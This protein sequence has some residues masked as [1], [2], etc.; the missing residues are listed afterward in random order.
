MAYNRLQLKLIKAQMASMQSSATQTNRYEIVIP[1]HIPRWV[2]PVARIAL[3]LTDVTFSA[4]CYLTAFAIRHYDSSIGLTELFFVREQNGDP[5]LGTLFAPY[6][7]LLPF[8]LIIR[9]LPTLY[10]DLYSLRGEFSY[11]DDAI[12]IFKAT[13]IGSL[14]IMTMAFLYRGVY[15]YRDFPYSRSIFLLDF[16]LALVVFLI[17]RLVVRRGQIFARHHHFNLI[18]TLVVGRGPQAAI[19]IDEMSK[20]PTL[21]YRVVGI[22]DTGGATSVEVNGNNNLTPFSSDPIAHEFF[23][24]VPVICNLSGLTEAIRSLQIN[25]VIITDP[26]VSADSLFDC[27]MLVGRTHAVE[28][29]I[30][31]SLSNCL[32]RKTEMDQIGTL[33]T[34]R[35]F[36]EPLSELAR[37]TKRTFDIIF[38]IFLTILFAPV[39][40]IIMLLIKLDSKGS[41]FYKQ[42]RV[43]MDGRIFIAYKFRTMHED[44]D[45]V[46][47]R[48]Y[49]SKFISGHP[50][51]NFGDE[52]KP[53]YKMMTDDRIT[54]VGSFIRKH[55][56]D[57]L[58][59][60]INVLRGEM[61]I[62]GPRPPIPYEVELYK[63]SQRRR[64]DMKPGL[65]GL[66]QVSGRNALTFD[67]TVQIDLLYIENW[68][69]LL[70]FKIILRTPFIM[71]HGKDGG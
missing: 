57:E 3:A 33:P 71:L 29:R 13:A 19:C 56:L 23:A 63:P 61:S 9:L 40:L 5:I 58:P 12:R 10:Y 65:T 66:W 15:T 43:G 8:V 42:E 16:F 28:F 17:I 18:P 59:Q 55:G 36:R 35:L 64:L 6:A 69:P 31:P 7:A 68:S 22:V 45:D 30:A 2:I 46:S 62:V 34:I 24:G 37:L 27:M 54:K 25:E 14:L 60:L 48:E 51:T 20:R 50:D 41:I 39:W 26:N 53:I 52:E 44:A 38:A 49:Q 47:H 4:L 11:L 1:A 70:D 21:G 32:P 67:E